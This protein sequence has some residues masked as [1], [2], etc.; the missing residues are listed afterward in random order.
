M[1]ELDRLLSLQ[2]G[3]L[4]RRQALEAGCTPADVRRRLR[5]REWVVVHPGVYVDHTGPLTWPQR[6]WAACLAHWPAVLAA[7]SAIR[8]QEDR[9]GAADDGADIEILVAHARRVVSLPGVRVRRARGFDATARLDLHPP[10]QRYD[11]AVLAVADRAPDELRAV[12]VLADACRSRRTS[13]SRLRTRAA[14]TARLARRTWLTT[15]LDDLDEGACS[16]LEQAYLTRVE[17][18]HG[19]PRGQR[20]QADHDDA[21]RRVYRDVAYA[22][23]GWRQLVELDGRLFHDSAHARD[24]D[25]ERDLDAALDGAAT[26]RLGYAQV[27]GRPCVTAAKIGRLLRT[28]GWDG[29][30]SACPRCAATGS[31]ASAV[32][33]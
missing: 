17:R 6:A 14:Q 9:T 16:V 24:R 25:L 23:P 15:L 20:Q 12:A 2:D 33:Y 4:A 3:V 31:G 5:R 18:A 30:P 19:L 26:V 29:R 11:D 32:P 22:G 21:G 7:R 28:R 27:L 13:P 8:A 10:R 1:H